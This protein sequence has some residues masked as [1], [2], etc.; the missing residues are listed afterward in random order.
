MSP[1]QVIT[2]EDRELARLMLRFREQADVTRRQ[3]ADYM[4][5]SCQMIAHYELANNRMPAVNFRRMCKFLGI[6]PDD[7]FDIMERNLSHD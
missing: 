4:K 6:S 5:C 3:M 1:R 2:D 7:I